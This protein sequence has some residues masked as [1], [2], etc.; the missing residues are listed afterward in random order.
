MLCSLLSKTIEPERC[1]KPRHCELPALG[2]SEVEQGG[3]G[4]EEE[5][6]GDPG[7]GEQV[8]VGGQHHEV[9][10]VKRTLGEEEMEELRYALVFNALF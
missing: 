3:E 2:V 9:G 4:V 1:E 5:V 6:G 8:V 10:V 7:E